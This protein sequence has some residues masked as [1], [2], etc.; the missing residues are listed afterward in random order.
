MAKIQRRPVAVEVF[1]GGELP[2]GEEWDYCEEC[3][4]ILAKDG[5]VIDGDGYDGLCAECA[6]KAE[7]E[8]KWAAGDAELE[9]GG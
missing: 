8:G 1:N 5:E 4:A 7:A 2:Y 6:D 9:A 3:S